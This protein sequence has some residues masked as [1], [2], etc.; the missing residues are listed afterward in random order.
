MVIHALTSASWTTRPRPRPAS[1]DGYAGSAPA[2][3]PAPAASPSLAWSLVGLAY[4]HDAR[5]LQQTPHWEKLPPTRI[6]LA[7]LNGSNT[8]EVLQRLDT[9]PARRALQLID[10]RELDARG[11]DHLALRADRERVAMA[12]AVLTGAP[13]LAVLEDPTEGLVARLR[14]ELG[15]VPAGAVADGLKSLVEHPSARMGLDEAVLSAPDCTDPQQLMALALPRCGARD[16]LELGK[17][18]LADR[19]WVEPAVAA[20]RSAC[21]SP[22][23]KDWAERSFYAAVAPVRDG[24][25]AEIVLAALPTLARAPELL[26]AWLSSIADHPVGALLGP[27]APRMTDLKARRH[28]IQAALEKPLDSASARS[29]LLATAARGGGPDREL[30]MG[31]W[32]TA[33]GEAA[34]EKADFS[35]LASLASDSFGCSASGAGALVRRALELSSG[36]LAEGLQAQLAQLSG[37]Q[38]SVEQALQHLLELAEHQAELSRSADPSGGIRLGADHVQVGGVRLPRTKV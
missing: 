26:G 24:S 10:Q 36:P 37:P 9:D 22:E 5:K 18:A 33:L 3:L 28:L 13:V 6:A 1:G 34:A 15:P 12:R 2:R 29:A 32:T 7:V 31:A 4:E 30:L 21:A 11:N 14:Q 35:A 25:R 17:R 20:L 16:G 19:P 38:P 8:R 27:V 23:M